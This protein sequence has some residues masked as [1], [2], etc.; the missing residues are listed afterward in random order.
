MVVV[1][2]VNIIEGTRTKSMTM[3]EVPGSARIQK[4]DLEGLA[5]ETSPVVKGYSK[6]Q[7][8]TDEGLLAGRIMMDGACHIEIVQSLGSIATWKAEIAVTEDDQSMA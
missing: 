1:R 8:G 3:F 4:L 6:D 5:A 7:I 2:G